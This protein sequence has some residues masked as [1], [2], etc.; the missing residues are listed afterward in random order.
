MDLV[1]RT[2]FTAPTILFAFLLT[3]AWAQSLSLTIG[4]AV[5][6]Q[7]YA[8][9]GAQ[10]V[11]RIN[12]CADLS[13]AQIRATAEGIVGGA[14]RSTPLRVVPAQPEGVYAISQAWG[15]EGKWV[16]A[17]SAGCQSDSAG[18]IVPVNGNG[19]LR[20][21]TQLLSHA[22]SQP[23]VEAALKAFTPSGR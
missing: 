21:S 16:I 3:P 8:V 10:F 4:N 11:F 5:A 7:T 17:I 13:R 22:P 15:T 9:K 1:M 23:E 20:E 14:R 2:K 18:A 19:F 12:G 6:G